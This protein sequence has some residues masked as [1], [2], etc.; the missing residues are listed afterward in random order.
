[1]CNAKVVL[2]LKQ[3]KRD[4]E[5]KSYANACRLSY[6][7]LHLQHPRIPT[8]PW[9]HV[10]D[11]RLPRWVRRLSNPRIV[12]GIRADLHDC[13]KASAS[14]FDDSHN[15]WFF[16]GERQR[17]TGLNLMHSARGG[18]QESWCGPGACAAST[19]RLLRHKVALDFSLWPQLGQK[20][21]QAAD[22][23]PAPSMYV[24]FYALAPGAHIIPHLGN[25]AR[26]T[27]H[28]ALEVPPHN[29]SRI[30]VADTV[31]AYTHP[32]QLLI[33]DDAYEH[34]VWNDA[35]TTRYVLGITIWHPELLRHLPK[36]SIPRLDHQNYQLYWG[37]KAATEFENTGMVYDNGRTS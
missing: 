11:L 19:C 17:W 29:L 3:L 10:D 4:S 37:Q 23:T 5:G 36:A 28:L 35:N 13:L 22:G 2:L 16:V 1:M 26:L 24:N 6:D 30:R 33:F 32:G 18:W 9:W 27:L 8:Q 21:L 15:D 25:D 31:V 7:A 14:G 12:K 34:E 20:A